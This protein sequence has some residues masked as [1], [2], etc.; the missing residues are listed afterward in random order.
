MLSDHLRDGVLV[1]WRKNSLDLR[2]GGQRVRES[3]RYLIL[4]TFQAC[5]KLVRNR[6]SAAI[7]GLFFL[8]FR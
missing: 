3:D 6:R 7:N 2:R 1:Q 8:M 4:R 5:S